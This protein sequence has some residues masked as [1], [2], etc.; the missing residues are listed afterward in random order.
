M[1]RFAPLVFIFALALTFSS[2][3]AE[4]TITLYS[5]RTKSLVD[6]IIE[7]FTKETGIKVVVKAGTTSAQIAQLLKDEGERSPADVIWVQDAGTLEALAKAK[8]FAELPDADYKNIADNFKTADHTWIATSGRA[9]VLAYSPERLKK[10]DLPASVFDLT[11]AKWKGKIGWSPA[12]ASF[13][14]FITAMRASYGEEKTTAWLKGIMAN[15]PKSFPNNRLILEEIASGGIDV[16]LP[17]HY[18]LLGFKK[19]KPNFP[20]AQ[21]F[22]KDGDIGNLLFP[23]A[24]AV[25]KS[26]K[27]PQAAQQFVEYLLKDGSQEFFS[28]EVNEF[29]VTKTAK[30]TNPLLDTKPLE[31]ATPKIKLDALQDLPGTVKLLKELGLL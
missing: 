9:R 29:P 7:R 20:V 1:Q 26:S 3:Q 17:N 15:E 18:Y 27:N 28:S 14:A 11:N 25:L 6:P 19:A 2:I 13:Q 10:E 12:N 23:A 24:A 30:I 4:E 22:F 8:L 31:T 21:T 5:G 16:G